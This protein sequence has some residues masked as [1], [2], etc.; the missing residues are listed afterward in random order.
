M[1]SI[2]KT[3]FPLVGFHSIC[4]P[5]L[6][7]TAATGDCISF[8]WKLSP[9]HLLFHCTSNLSLNPKEVEKAVNDIL[10]HFRPANVNDFKPHRKTNGN[11]CFFSPAWQSVDKTGVFRITEAHQTLKYLLLAIYFPLPS[12]L[13]YG[14]SLLFPLSL[15]PWDRQGNF[16]QIADILI[17]IWSQ[18][19]Q[20]PSAHSASWQSTQHFEL[21]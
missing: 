21:S 11:I 17:Y 18:P 13:L 9:Q 7:T 2:L 1:T 20:W 19:R 16:P 6:S 4:H 14:K 15:F 8:R 5:S 10:C 3:S 12:C